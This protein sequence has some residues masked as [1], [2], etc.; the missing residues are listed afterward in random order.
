M[1]VLTLGLWAFGFAINKVLWENNPEKIFYSFELNEE[2][3]ES[4]KNNRTHPYFFTGYFLPNNIELIDNYDDIISEIDLI[5]LAMPAQ[6]VSWAVTSLQHKLKKWV[7]FLNLA[8]WIDIKQNKT[9]SQLL[10][11][12]LEWKDYNYAV[13]SWWMIASEV[14]E[15]KPLW[16][17]LWINNTAIG[18]NVQLMLQNNN[19]QIKLQKDIL[20]IEMYGSLKNIMAILAGYYEAKWLGK[21][22]IGY[23]LVNFYDEMKG[24]VKLYWWNKEIDFSYYSLGWDIVAT[25]F[26]DSRNKYFWNLLWSGKNIT[27][28]LDILKSENKH[29]EGYETLKAVYNKIEDK[30]GFPIVKELYNK[31]V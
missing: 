1:K 19:L 2:I 24:I 17:D 18:K 22:S 31:I 13:L 7:T 25:C 6:F 23:Y 26:W 16:A 30:E 20:N 12:S 29:A 27:E 10:S 21:S 3:K 5:I 28:V 11:E 8:K 4:V 14:V 9:I 15:W